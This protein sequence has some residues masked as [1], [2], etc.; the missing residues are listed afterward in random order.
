M[1]ALIFFLKK[2][3]MMVMKLAAR[4]KEIF[5]FIAGNLRSEKV[6]TANE[7]TRKKFPMSPL[8]C[9]SFCLYANNWR[10]HIPN[11]SCFFGLVLLNLF[12]FY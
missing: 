10:K 8:L 1:V 4:N 12:K 5:S 2:G 6:Y 7:R 9:N 11:I 3:Y